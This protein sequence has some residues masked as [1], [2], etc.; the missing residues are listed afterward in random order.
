MPNNN[1]RNR[2]SNPTASRTVT[3]NFVAKNQWQRGGVHEKTT[4]AKRKNAK[5]ALQRKIR[6]GKSDSDFFV[7]KDVVCKVFKR[8]LKYTIQ[9]YCF[10]NF[11]STY[12]NSQ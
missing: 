12:I 4:K 6:V 9:E 2:A 8:L 3:R 10:S 1:R 7:H 5:Q 11:N